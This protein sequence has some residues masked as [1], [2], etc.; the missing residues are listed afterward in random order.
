MTIRGL[1]PASPPVVASS[2]P[3]APG[4]AKASEPGLWSMLT[5]AERA[6]FLPPDG[7][8]ALGYGRSGR[9]ERGAP[10]LGQR[11]DVRG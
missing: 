11:V 2:R 7:E 1:P 3:V 9:A 4:A 10:A 5:P 6:F 8:A